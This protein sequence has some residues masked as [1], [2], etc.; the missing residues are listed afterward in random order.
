MVPKKSG[1]I[2]ATTKRF[3]SKGILH[4]MLQ[5]R[6]P[7]QLS[8]RPVQLVRSS[9]ALLVTKRH[10]A[11]INRLKEGRS[12]QHDSGEHIEGRKYAETARQNENKESGGGLEGLGLGG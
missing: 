3:M 11:T 4:R 6:Y 12:R 2:E 7:G 10:N 1:I 5:R 8:V 9:I